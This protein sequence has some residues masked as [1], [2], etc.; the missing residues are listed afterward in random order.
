MSAHAGNTPFPN[1]T[2]PA[3]PVLSA[4]AI[5][6]VVGPLVLLS[7]AGLP[8]ASDLREVAPAL[9]PPLPLLLVGAG[10]YPAARSNA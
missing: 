8:L 3:V 4:G 5:V 7:G 6:P 2:F 9:S 1:R 10:R